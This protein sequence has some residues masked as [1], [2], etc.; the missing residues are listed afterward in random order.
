MFDLM[1]SERNNK[2]D[3]LSNDVFG[4]SS[5]L[6]NDFMNLS[7]TGF[8][9]DIKEKDEEYLIEAEL[10]GLDKDDITLEVNDNTLTI[11]AQNEENIEKE[12]GDYLRK[13]RKVGR[14]QRNFRL[15][16]VDEDNIEAE[17]DSGLLK[18]TLPK[19]EPGRDNRRT[20]DIN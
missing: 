3:S 18:I 6:F 16:N 7:N 10:P 11:T 8:R 1:P 20:I 2:S 15:Q 12:D 14:Y 9:T 19:E 4:L 17:Y 5:G 13:E